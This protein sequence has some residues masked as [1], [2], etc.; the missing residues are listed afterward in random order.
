[1]YSTVTDVRNALAPG[2]QWTGTA[3]TL[4]D[5]EIED[6][7]RQADSRIHS[8]LRLRYE[9]PVEMVEQGDPPQP[10]E[11]APAPVRYW[12]RDIAAYLATLTFKRN[13][14]VS[15]D[16]PVRLR[17]NAAMSE[18]TDARK[19]VITLPFPPPVPDDSSVTVVNQYVG[20][21]F[22]PEDFDLTHAGHARRPGTWPGGPA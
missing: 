9:I 15:P 5:P 7:I 10:H 2:G 19:G 13:K 17:H 21:L 1:M 14:D 11:V 8:Y 12:S 4:E 6:A 18:L 20:R 22:G 16:D 3:A